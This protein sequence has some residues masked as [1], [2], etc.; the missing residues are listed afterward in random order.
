MSHTDKD[1]LEE[2]YRLEPKLRENES[3][4]LEI[5]AKMRTTKPEII[6]N[7]DFRE[8]LKTEIMAQLRS[9]KKS[10]LQMFPFQFSLPIIS[11]AFAC[12]LVGV[13][14]S[15]LP[16]SFFH[17]NPSFVPQI[18]EIDVHFSG[19]T[20]QFSRPAPATYQPMGLANT[21]MKAE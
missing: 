2:L 21:M 4:I 10:P 9:Q 15:E 12:L 7:G 5:L 14:I 6:M 11:T 17:K 19:D 3:A 1:I 8:A 13:F 20:L 16:V 18:V